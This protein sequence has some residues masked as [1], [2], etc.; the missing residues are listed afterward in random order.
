MSK[1]GDSN[2]NERPDFNDDELIDFF[3]FIIF[4]KNYIG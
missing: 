3:D 4:A 1:K 2:F